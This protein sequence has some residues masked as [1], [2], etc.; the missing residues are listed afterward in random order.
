MYNTCTR[1]HNIVKDVSQEET[2]DCL[3]T[4]STMYAGG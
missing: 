2:Y 1:T 3:A 4:T